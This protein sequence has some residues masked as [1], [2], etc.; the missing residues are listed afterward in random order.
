MLNFWIFCCF[1]C[2]VSSGVIGKVV[3]MGNNV[4]LSFDDI[5]A[6]F[7][8]RVKGTGECGTLYQAEP[9]DA[10]APLAN[11]SIEESVNQPFVLII[12]GG[13]SF[14]EKVRRAQAAGF[15]A[16]IIY[17]DDDSDL[18]AMAGT[19]T[20]IVIHAVFVSKSSGLKLSKFA[21]ITSMQLWIIPGYEN[22]AWSIMAISFISLLAM[23]AVLATCFFVRRHRIRREHPQSSRVR[24]F[25]GMSSRLVKAMPSLVFTAVLEDNC[26]SATCAICLEDYN[27]GDKLRILPCRHKFHAMC[28]DA[29][30]TSWRTF[31]PV[32]KRDARTANGEPPASER[33]PLLSSNP[34]SMASSTILS[35]T[36]SS[37][38]APSSPAI[39]IGQT[40]RTHS[41]VHSVSSTPYTL[42]SH[43]QSPYIT[44]S[45]SSL[46]IRNI[47]SSSYRSSFITPSRSSLDVRNMASSSHGLR[48]SHLVSSNSLGYP[49]VSPL[50]SRHLS[51]YYPS[52]GNGSSSYMW[53]SSQQQPH[54]LRYNDSAASFSPYASAHSLPEC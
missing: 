5:E 23:S 41:N 26:T 24:E 35:S 37:S 33:T 39:Q 8:P 6:S 3:L 21:G 46:D 50:N 45:R 38:Y 12:R 13:C 16:A 34:A 40:S 18:V 36:Y 4:T 27:V 11:G 43:H 17:N 2:L 54:P 53:S 22:S 32:C 20:G 15:K 42:Q 29:W 52:P 9:L 48:A 30:L 1:L 14:D 47:A 19:A 44:P 51:S 10:C 49:S 28:V 31:C 25:H 7:A